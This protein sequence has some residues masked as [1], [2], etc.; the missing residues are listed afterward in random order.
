MSR[1]FRLCDANKNPEKTDPIAFENF[2]ANHNCFA[3]YK[4]SA[5]NMEVTGAKFSKPGR[6]L[7]TTIIP[8]CV[9][10][11]KD[12]LL[13]KCFDCKTQNQNESFNDTVWQR[14]QKTNYV[15][16]R[17][18]SLGVYD[19]VAVFNN[20]RKVSIDIYE[21]MNMR[22]RFSTSQGCR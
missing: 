16:Y 20:E 19:A 11:C 13:K 12:E 22:P 21:N 6:S 5:P 15:G 2:K 10:L 3:N 7:D 4:G 18:F 1:F 9:D 8:I 17:Q 14:L